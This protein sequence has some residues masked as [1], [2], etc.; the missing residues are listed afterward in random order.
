MNEREELIDVSINQI[1]KNQIILMENQKIILEYI[2]DIKQ[3]EKIEYVG[4]YKD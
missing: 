3:K 2:K 4:F 1:L